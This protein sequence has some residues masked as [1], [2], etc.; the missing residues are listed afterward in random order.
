MQQRQPTR[1]STSVAV[2]ELRMTTRR[3]RRRCYEPRCVWGGLGYTEMMMERVATPQSAAASRA[4]LNALILSKRDYLFC[5]IK[6]IIGLHQTRIYLCYTPPSRLFLPA[7]EGLHTFDTGIH[8]HHTIH[9]SFCSLV[10][11]LLSLSLSLSYPFLACELCASCTQRA[12]LLFMNRRL[13]VARRSSRFFTYPFQIFL[14]TICF[15]SQFFKYFS[16]FFV[17]LVFYLF[18]FISAAVNLNFE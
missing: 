9:F 14:L 4:R 15:N 11:L 7:S 16:Q 10:S 3:R 2:Q 6:T 12:T 13:S 5:C 8:L 1:R 17:I 18:I